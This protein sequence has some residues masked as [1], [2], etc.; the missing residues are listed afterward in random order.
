MLL[1]PEVG[2]LLDGGGLVAREARGQDCR[3]IFAFCITASA[4]EQSPEVSLVQIFGDAASAPLK[5]S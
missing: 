3:Q 1:E 5:G 4:G 2:L